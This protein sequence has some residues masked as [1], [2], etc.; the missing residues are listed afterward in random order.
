MK[1]GNNVVLYVEDDKDFRD[2]M[3]A[4]LEANGYV[5]SRPL[6]ATRGSRLSN[7]PTR[8]SSSST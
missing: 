3:R 2:S 4:V 5:M 1:D 6:P 7:S 8:T